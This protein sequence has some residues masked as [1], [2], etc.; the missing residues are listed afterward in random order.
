MAVDQLMYKRNTIEFVP[1]MTIPG[2]HR[3]QIC[4][5]CAWE[6]R[7]SK[8]KSTLQAR[9]LLPLDHAARQTACVA[10]TAAAGFL[11]YEGPLWD[12]LSTVLAASMLLKDLACKTKLSSRCSGTAVGGLSTGAAPAR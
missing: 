12:L 5:C 6:I 2:W 11:G 7:R 9:I 10:A 1:R 3:P 4:L 8:A